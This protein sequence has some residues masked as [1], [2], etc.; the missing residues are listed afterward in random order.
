MIQCIDLTL[1]VE[2]IM[3]CKHRLITSLDNT[4]MCIDGKKK[5]FCCCN[6]PDLPPSVCSWAGVLRSAGTVPMAGTDNA[7]STLL[8]TYTHVG[9]TSCP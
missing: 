2:H 6:L 1:K 9:D 4:Y 3:T 8:K 5:R 7:P